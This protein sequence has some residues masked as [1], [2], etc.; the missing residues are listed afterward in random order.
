MQCSY[1]RLCSKSLAMGGPAPCPVLACGRK[2]S[3]RSSQAPPFQPSHGSPAPS[4]EAPSAC[5]SPSSPPPSTHCTIEPKCRPRD[6]QLGNE[7][8][9]NEQGTDGWGWRSTHASGRPVHSR[10]LGPAVWNTHSPHLALHTLSAQPLGE[11]QRGTCRAGNSCW[12][13]TPSGRHLAVPPHPPGAAHVVGATCEPRFGVGRQAVQRLQHGVGARKNEQNLQ[14]QAAEHWQHCSAEDEQV[15]ASPALLVH[16][17]THC[18]AT[19]HCLATLVCMRRTACGA[20]SESGTRSS[21]MG[22]ALPG[23]HTARNCSTVLQQCGA[24]AGGREVGGK[25]SQARGSS[26]G[27]RPCPGAHRRAE[28]ASSPPPPPPRPERVWSTAVLACNPYRTSG[29]SGGGRCVPPARG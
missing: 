14:R 21:T 24:R 8:R 12:H 10:N 22:S 3:A 17:T 7:G 6:V 26:G 29:A 18:L 27:K 1:F 9:G 25:G 5:G 20:S 15:G 11:P 28:Q 2:G 4:C 23:F 13:C 16:T 19:P